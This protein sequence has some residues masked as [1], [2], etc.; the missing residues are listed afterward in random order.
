MSCRGVLTNVTVRARI[1]HVFPLQATLFG[2]GEPAADRSFADAVR[3]DLDGTSW[4]EFVPQWLGGADTLFEQILDTVELS[5]RTGIRMYESVVDEPRLTS[6]WH[7]Q[8]GDPEPLPI[9]TTLREMMIARYHRPF[10]SLGVNLYRDGNDSVAWH[11]DRHRHHTTDPVVVLLSLGAPRPLKLRPRGGGPSRSWDLGRGDLFAMGG[12]CQH[13]W[14]H[15]VPKLAR[16]VGPRMSV[17]F[18]HDTR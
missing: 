15:C 2:G 1:E 4:V 18:R 12:A 8:S 5:Q 16:A 9:L 13:D 6:W 10:D 11:G 3:I 14:E 17:A 7:A